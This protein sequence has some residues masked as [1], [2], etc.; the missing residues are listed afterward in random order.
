M[1]SM[2]GLVELMIGLVEL[3]IRSKVC[4]VLLEMVIL[5]CVEG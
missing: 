2:I 4:D 3:M 1:M 5:E